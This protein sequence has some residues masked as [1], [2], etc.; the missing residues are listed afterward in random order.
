MAAKSEG[1]RQ[2]AGGGGL[3]GRYR[4]DTLLQVGDG[5]L[6]SVRAGIH[7]AVG[8]GHLGA[9][10]RCETLADALVSAD[11]AVQQ[12]RLTAGWTPAQDIFAA[13]HKSDF[14]LWPTRNPGVRHA[15]TTFAGTMAGELPRWIVS[16]NAPLAELAFQVVASTWVKV[17]PAP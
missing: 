7:H 14:P 13:V 5:L 6:D 8:A 17:A 3:G 1:G 2:I 11:A 10:L 16:C 12:A 15:N 9:V 4:L